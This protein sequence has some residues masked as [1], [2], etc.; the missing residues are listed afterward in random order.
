MPEQPE[1]TIRM[2]LVREIV[3]VGCASIAA[4]VAEGQMGEASG[5]AKELHEY[6]EACFVAA[7]GEATIMG[8]GKVWIQLKKGE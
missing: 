6:L 5:L 2:G 4:A 3:R 1:G 8:D 7:E